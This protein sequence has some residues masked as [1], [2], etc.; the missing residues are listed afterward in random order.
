MMRKAP[1][2][3]PVLPLA[4]ALVLVLALS[5]CG[6]GAQDAPAPAPAADP[7]VIALSPAQIARMGIQTAP[8]QASDALPMGTVPGTVSL[9]PEARVAVTT[10]FAG[11]VLR[12]MV[13]AGQSVRKGEALAV[14]RAAD[15][16]QFG[17]ALARARAQLPVD[18]AQAARM[19][20]L[21]REGIIAP[22]RADEA[23]AAL[24]ATRAT[25]A[26]NNR[27]LGMTGAGPDGTITLRSPID[28]RVASVSVD[29]GAA[30]GQ[31]GA[32]FVVENPAQLR[33]DLQIPERLA[34]AV[35]P[36][37]A[38]ALDQDGVSAR[39]TILSVAPSLDPMTRSLA[40]KASLA[41]GSALVPGKGVMAAIAGHG[42]RGVAIP[43]QAVARVDNTDQVFL[44]VPQG[45]R[46]IKVTVSGQIGGQ[47]FVAS[48]L[49]PGDVVA[50]GGVAELKSLATGG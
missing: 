37:M 3:R 14:V 21:A 36:G 50:S 23:K 30:V 34:G 22:A 35:H 33:L 8:A 7:G 49:K 25:I 31:A 5:A 44:R 40:A 11:T 12:V 10:P 2:L 43:A 41:P 19:A 27:L 39:G 9:P 32:P 29:T 13:I 28:G 18:E 17:G 45:F 4:S 20:Q 47:A 16:V 26:E 1:A 42:G 24:G 15:T 46:R 38:V 48:G 6:K